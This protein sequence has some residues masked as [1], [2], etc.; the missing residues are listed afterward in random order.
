MASVGTAV[1]CFVSGKLS[2]GNSGREG[3][4]LP[5]SIEGG[6]RRSSAMIATRLEPVSYTHLRAHETGAYL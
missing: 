6:G 2:V 4:T 5:R 3:S 1:C